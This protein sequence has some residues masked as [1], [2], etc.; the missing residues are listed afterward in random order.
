MNDPYQILGVTRDASDREIKKAYRD[1]S[2]KYHPDSYAGKSE[3]EANA[4]AE[5]FKQVQEAYNRIVDERSGKATGSYGDFG[6][7]GGFG[8]G[9]GRQNYSEDEQHMMAAMNY[10]RARRSELVVISTHSR[11]TFV[12]AFSAFSSVTRYLALTHPVTFPE[13]IFAQPFFIL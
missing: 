4:A 9:Q 5:K 12:A 1:L 3:A 8:A 7:F 2:R 6:G 10:I 13:T 11:P